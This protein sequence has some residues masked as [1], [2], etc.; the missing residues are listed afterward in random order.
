MALAWLVKATATLLP[1][2][3]QLS[4]KA[5]PRF[6]IIGLV[7]DIHFTAL[8]SFF[9]AAYWRNYDFVVACG[10]A[11]LRPETPSERE[12]FQSVKA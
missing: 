3:R 6:D 10:G 8:P 9:D 4:G 7:M 2:H 11:V 5:Y 1:A 12:S